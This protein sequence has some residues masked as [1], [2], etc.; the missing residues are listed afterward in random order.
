MLNL[1]GPETTADVHDYLVRLFSDKDLIPL[2]AQRCVPYPWGRGRF[3]LRL[4]LLQLTWAVDSEEKN[5]QD[6]EAV[7]PDW[8]GLAHKDVDRDAGPGD[9]PYPG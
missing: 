1:G 2:P 4:P 5:A 6:S 9:G 8:W 7:Q 3:S